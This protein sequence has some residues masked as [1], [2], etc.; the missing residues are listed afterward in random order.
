MTYEERRSGHDRR[1]LVDQKLSRA[2]QA[3]VWLLVILVVVVS[4]FLAVVTVIT[5][6]HSQ[7]GI[8][9]TLQEV[10]NQANETRGVVIQNRQ[11][12][13]ALL[14]ETA[15]SQSVS[16]AGIRALAETFGVKIATLPGETVAHCTA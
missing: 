2:E 4:T 1:A 10:Q 13:S 11:Q 15:R 12:L 7:R 5:V 6:V 8:A 3:P 14:C 9:E 16:L